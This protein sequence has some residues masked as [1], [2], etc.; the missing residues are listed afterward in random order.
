MPVYSRVF[1]RRLAPIDSKF[2]LQRKICTAASDIFRHLVAV[3]KASSRDEPFVSTAE[4][5]Q[6]APFQK[7][8]PI[9]RTDAPE[10]VSGPRSTDQYVE[11]HGQ[12]SSG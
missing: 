10:S 2:V 8:L 6:S 11:Q 12:S 1:V 9:K 4:G 7:Q 5:A 3:K